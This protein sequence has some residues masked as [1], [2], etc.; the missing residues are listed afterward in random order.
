MPFYAVQGKK[1]Q[2]G[3]HCFIAP[4]T[5]IIGDVTIGD[6]CSIWFGTVIRG[7]VNSITI[8]NN[9]NIQDNSVVHCHTQKDTVIGNNVTIGHGVLIHASDIKDYALIGNRSVVHNYTVINEY[10]LVGAGAVVTDR[11]VVA[12]KTLV[13]G[14]PAKF[15]RN[16]NQ[17][18]IEKLV[19]NNNRYLRLK[20]EY[21]DDFIE[22]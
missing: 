5:I 4:N 3:N 13:T 2:I 19:W 21:L 20:N 17:E 10:A 7:D 1:P 9:T 12:K 11:T 22:V 18:D 14:I 15:K 6:N 8:G 16:L